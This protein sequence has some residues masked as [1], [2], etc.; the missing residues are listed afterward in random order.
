MELGSPRPGCRVAHQ[1]A[2]VGGQ[3]VS[4]EAVSRRH[5]VA[6]NTSRNVMPQPSA[7]SDLSE[8]VDTQNGRYG[9]FTTRTCSALRTLAVWISYV[10]MTANS[11]QLPGTPLS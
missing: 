9:A 8:P 4:P 1:A 6:A 11:C 10:P 2:S 7:Q 3:K 5:F